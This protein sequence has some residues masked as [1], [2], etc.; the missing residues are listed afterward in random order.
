MA[1]IALRSPQYKSFTPAS[2]ANSVKMT[3]T[4][5][6]TLRYTIIKQVSSTTPLAFEI[7]ELCRDYLEIGYNST[8]VGYT[9]G[10]VIAI[11]SHASTDG[12]GSALNSAAY[13]DIGFDGYGTFKQG[14]NPVVV[15][16]APTWLM[17]FDPNH[18]GINDKYFAYYP[19]GYQ[20]FL[21]YITGI[22]SMAYYKFT[23]TDTTLNG[24]P[25][26]IRMNI[27][28]ICQTKYGSGSKIRFVNKFGAIQ[29]LWFFLKHNKTTSRKQETFQTNIINN[30]GVY[31]TNRA[32]VTAFNTTAKQSY[33]L[34]SG[35]YPE[36][37]N[38]WFE[39]LMLS[40]QI[41]VS[42]DTSTNPTADVVIPVTVKT[43]SFQEKTSLNDR[44]IEYT[45]E[46]EMA[47]DYINNIR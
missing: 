39:E 6:G 11:S 45:F 40:E 35:Y 19:I 18:T 21:P 14:S 31:D 15:S 32:S 42:F 26:G 37:C 36:W 29:E 30:T 4:I 20:G 1:Y 17:S 28:R 3:I 25:A 27:E 2:G 5:S 9:I 34:S 46:F 12:S 44:L 8:P 23:T 7:A 22:G 13:S 24:T 41:W 16:S 33:K 38:Q 47:A 10:I 43:S